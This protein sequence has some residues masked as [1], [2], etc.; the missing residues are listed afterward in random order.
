MSKVAIK[1]NPL[2]TGT[3]T[4]E[5]PNSDT[6]STVLLPVGGGSVVLT[7]A[8]QTL[9]AKTLTSPTITGTGTA[10]FGNLSYTGTLTGGTGVINIG[11]GQ[12]YKDA[13]GNVGIGTSSPTA[14]LTLDGGTSAD[15]LRI[16]NDPHYYRLGRNSVSGPFEFYGTQ[17]GVTG[18]IFGGVD[19]ERM[20]INSAGNVGIGTS[21]PSA[22]LTIAG[23]ANGNYN[24]GVLLSRSGGNLYAMYP[25][26]ND[27]YIRSVT[28]GADVCRFTYAGNFQFNNGYGSLATAYGCRAW[29]NFNGTGTVAIRA[30]GNVSSITDRGAGEFT[31]NFTT[32]MPDANYCAVFGATAVGVAGPVAVYDDAI[33]PTTTQL[34]IETGDANNKRDFVYTTVAIF[35]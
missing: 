11:S 21:S 32:A 28:N 19:G 27:L 16:G 34:A 25:D 13:S 35:R 22:R 7:D 1:G 3:F 29:V 26:T 12:L 33:A 31:V 17:S 6:D 18:Y 10:A 8:T 15:Q 30:S 24:D 20:R 14:R 4:I 9:T 23:G 5:A 2:G